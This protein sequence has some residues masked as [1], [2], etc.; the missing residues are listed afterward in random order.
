MDIEVQTLCFISI[1]KKQHYYIGFVKKAKLSVLLHKKEICPKEKNHIST[2][3]Y[4]KIV[5]AS[6]QDYS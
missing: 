1:M 6:K 3:L 4:V 2:L 5:I